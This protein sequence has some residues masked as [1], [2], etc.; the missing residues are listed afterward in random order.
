MIISTDNINEQLLDIIKE[1]NINKLYIDPNKV[2]NKD[3]FEIIYESPDADYIV[4]DNIDEIDNSKNSGFKIKIRSKDD[5]EL[6]AK[7]SEKGAKFVIVEADDWKIIPLENIIARL[8]KSNTKI[9]TRADTADEV[10]TMFNVLELGVDGVILNSSD[11]SI[12]RSALAYLGNIKVKLIPVEVIQVREAGSG[13]RVCV[14]T[15]SILK[16]GEGMLVGNRSNFLFLVHNESVGSS[17]TSPRP[18]RVNAGAVH[19]YTL[20]ANGKTKYLSE[21]ESGD[22]VLIIDKDGNARRVTV[23]RA[24]IE[25]RPMILIKAKNN[26][27]VGSIIAQNAETI[28]FVRDDNTLISVTELKEGD[29]ILAYIK[30]SK[31]RHFG[32][33]VDEYILEK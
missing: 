20:M 27:E 13:E 14:D 3:G 32:M 26:S 19:C 31:G 2:S 18:F 21:L 25:T 30:E 24:K 16:Y 8:N 7:A 10:R 15:T 12:I 9:Y 11:P 23:G 28:R 29:K 1:Y 6:I 4:Y 17:F 22:E 5:E 33:E